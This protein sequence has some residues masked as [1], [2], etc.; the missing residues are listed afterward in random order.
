MKKL[1][2]LLALSVIIFTQCMKSPDVK[3][4]TCVKSPSIENKNDF[5]ISN[6]APLAPNPFIKLPIGAIE[7]GTWL[8]KWLELERDGMIGHLD[9]VSEWLSKSDNGWLDPQGKG[10]YGWEELPYWLKGYGDLGY[11]LKDQD[12]IA[13]AKVWL[14]AA[15]NSQRPDGYFGPKSMQQ[16]NDYWPNMVMLNCLQTYYEA[17]NDQRVLPFMAKFFHYLDGLPEDNIM[18]IP[19]YWTYVRGGDLF[20]SILWTYNRTGEE[21]LLD[22]AKKVYRNTMDWSFILD[23]HGVNMAQGFREGT[24]YYQVNKD[25]AYLT[26]AD[27]NWNNFRK[28]FG[29]FPGGLYAS[30]ENC[31]LGCWDPHNGAETCTMVEFMNS[32]EMLISITG[33]SKWA[34]RLEDVAFNTFPAALTPDYKGL[35]YITCANAV[36]LDEGNRS[37]ILQNQGCLLTYSPH[38]LYRCCQHNV[39]HGWPYMAE[40]LWYATPGNGLCAMFYCENNLKAKAGDGT[41][42]SIKE[43]TKYPFE[44][45]VNF[46]ISLA[47]NST[48][49]LY[50]RIPGW[51]KNASLAV[52]GKKAE[53]ALTAGEYAM[54]NRAW[55]N[56]DKVTLTFPM[57][58][59]VSKWEKNKNSVSVNRGPLTYSLKIAEKWEKRKKGGEGTE[60][61]PEWNVFPQSAWNYGLLINQDNPASSIEVVNKEWPQSNQPFEANSSPIELKIKAK[62]IPTWKLDDMNNV[63]WLPQSPVKTEEPAEDVTLIPMG[64]ARLRISS[65]PVVL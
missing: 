25:P 2:N 26:Y 31:R 4:V 56:G 1:F 43:T 41:D 13:K 42:V 30:D 50:F 15:L 19:L 3:E 55:A 64:C 49:P 33:D 59:T 44:E 37:P 5:Y 7:P 60:K 46:E 39:S 65:F 54:V 53:A 45:A 35:H 11:V 23:W 6:K 47:K 12:V 20:Q 27:N 21:K 57:D 34:D 36:Y 29:Q 62:K 22:I 38:T 17:T 58:I 10:K 9:E 16:K 14:D 28:V 40:H 51:C 24:Q 18:P 48:F 32:A 61:W 63:G 8:K 52:N